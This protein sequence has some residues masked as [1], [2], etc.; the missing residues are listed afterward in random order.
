MTAVIRFALAILHAWIIMQSSI[1][2]VFTAPHP[3]VMIYT[4][5]SRTDSAIR[6]LVS[7]IPLVVISALERGRP[8]L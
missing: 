1:R 6:T 3:V 2:D 7:P 4:S 5:F 8:M